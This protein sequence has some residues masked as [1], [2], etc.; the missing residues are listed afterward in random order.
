MLILFSY[1]GPS[2]ILGSDDM[3]N[4]VMPVLGACKLLHFPLV[5]M[6]RRNKRSLLFSY[7]V[8]SLDF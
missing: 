1:F 7:I 4:I 8:G 3:E 2:G 6:N 5:V